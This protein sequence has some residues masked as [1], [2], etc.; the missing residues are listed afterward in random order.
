[1]ETVGGSALALWAADEGLGLWVFLGVFG[2]LGLGL[3]VPSCEKAS[4]SKPSARIRRSLPV[5]R[6]KVHLLLRLFQLVSLQQRLS[7]RPVEDHFQTP[8]ETEKG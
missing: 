7:N 6:E 2:V 8:S 5:C 3:R 4:N 1:M